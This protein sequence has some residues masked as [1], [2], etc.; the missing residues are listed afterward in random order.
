MDEYMKISIPQIDGGRPV[1]RLNGSPDGL[2]CLHLELH[3]ADE[4]VQGRQ[5]EDWP[6]SSRLLGNREK[7]GVK[8]R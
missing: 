2:H 5:I 8:S 1:P 6:P 7:A 4:S 3:P